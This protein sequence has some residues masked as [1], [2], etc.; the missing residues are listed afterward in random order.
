[1]ENEAVISMPSKFGLT[2]EDFNKIIDAFCKIPALTEVWLYGSRAKGNFQPYSDIDITLKGVNLDLTTRNQLAL[3]LDD[4]YLPYI[5]DISLLSH[6]K[7]QELLNHIMRMGVLI[8][9]QDTKLIK[10]SST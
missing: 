3:L 7:N 8:Y 5:F 4:L 6:I 2:I 9:K 10:P 1:M